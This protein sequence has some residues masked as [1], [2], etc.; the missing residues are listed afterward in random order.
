MKMTNEQITNTMVR[1]HAIN[2]AIESIKTKKLPV[3]DQYAIR[4]CLAKITDDFKVL[5]E[6]RQALVS[7]YAEKDIGGKVIEAEGGGIT[8]KN[9]ME[10]QKDIKELMD[11]EIDLGIEKIV[12]DFEV[13]GDPRYDVLTGDEMDLILPLIEEKKN[14]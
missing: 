14:D 7:H 12:V 5:E 4:R 9:V 3:K 13:W 10:F 2:P 11:A 1:N 8:I 6:A